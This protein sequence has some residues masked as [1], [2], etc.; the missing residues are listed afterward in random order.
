MKD[1]EEDPMEHLSHRMQSPELLEE[2]TLPVPKSAKGVWDRISLQGSWG[3]EPD[4]AEASHQKDTSSKPP[5]GHPSKPRERHHSQAAEGHPSWD[6]RSPQHVQTRTPH[7]VQRT[8]Q[9]HPRSPLHP[10]EHTPVSP[11]DTIGPYVTPASPQKGT[12][13]SD[14]HCPVANSRG[15]RSDHQKSYAETPSNLITAADQ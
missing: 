14:R 13:Q 15:S 7:P 6:P 4:A 9:L 12:Q 8:P 2:G 5:E 3:Q 10:H 11:Q 1:F